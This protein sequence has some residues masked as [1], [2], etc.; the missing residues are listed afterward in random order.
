MR[1]EQKLITVTEAQLNKIEKALDKSNGDW[2][3][4][5]PNSTD[6]DTTLIPMEYDG[7]GKK[8][9]KYIVNG[10]KVREAYKALSIGQRVSATLI[11]GI[12]MILWLNVKYK[13]RKNV[14]RH[15][16]INKK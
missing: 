8:N 10:T 1:T 7:K 6:V 15:N 11:F 9:G 5:K 13:K 14:N 4:I 2:F 12:G 16:I 3:P